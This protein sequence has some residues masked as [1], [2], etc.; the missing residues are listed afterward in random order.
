MEH[1]CKLLEGELGHCIRSLITV[2]VVSYTARIFKLAC[3]CTLST[4][5]LYKGAAVSLS[6]HDGH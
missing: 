6:L 5:F 2:A 1:A 4:C 3:P